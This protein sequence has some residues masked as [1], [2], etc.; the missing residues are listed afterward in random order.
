VVPGDLQVELVGV[1]GAYPF[2]GGAWQRF[3]GLGC[4]CVPLC[5]AD[6]QRKRRLLG[7]AGAGRRYCKVQEYHETALHQLNLQSDILLGEGGFGKVWWARDREFL[8]LTTEDLVPRDAG[9]HE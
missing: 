5:A 1:V 3:A 7:A 6:Y 4:R 9:K 8:R 2:G